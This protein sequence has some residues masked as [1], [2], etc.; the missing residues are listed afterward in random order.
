MKRG[1]FAFVSKRW[2][3]TGLRTDETLYTRAIRLGGVDNL[4]DADESWDL[5]NAARLE[6]SDWLSAANEIS[7][8]QLRDAFDRCDVRLQEDFKTAQRDRSNENEDRVRFQHLTA[9]RHRD[10]LLV[11]QRE[12]LE[13]Y[14]AEDRHRL[15]PMTEG[16][17]QAIERRFALHLERLSQQG[18][19]TSSVS[20]VCYGVVQVI[21]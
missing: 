21:D 20:D 19:M 4:L 8:E 5:L 12:L 14:R 6:G 16:R 2:T 15:I 17:I 1:L 3:F 9:E 18:T 13:R 11:V 7:V 10:R